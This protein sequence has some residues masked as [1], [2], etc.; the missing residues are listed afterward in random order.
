MIIETK[1]SS[2]FTMAATR[3]AELGYGLGS[4]D[5][6]EAMIDLG[7]GRRLYKIISMHPSAANHRNIVINWMPA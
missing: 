7:H 6:Q 2:F 3:V 4:S 1:K 5:K